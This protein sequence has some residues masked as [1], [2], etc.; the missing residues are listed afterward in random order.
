MNR[1]TSFWVMLVTCVVAQSSTVMHVSAAVI[2]P[3]LPA[4]SQY[5]IV[6]VT[7]DLTTATS[8]VIGDYNNFV[9]SEAAQSA[10]LVALGVQWNAVVSTAGGGIAKVNAPST[11][12]PVYNT[13]GIEVASGATGLYVGSSLPL[14]SPIQ[15]DQFGLASSPV[16]VWTGSTASGNASLTLGSSF[17][18]VGVSTTSTPQSWMTVDAIPSGQVATLYALSTPITVIPEPASLTLLGTAALLLGGFA[19]S[20]ARTRWLG[21]DRSRAADRG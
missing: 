5:Q 2:L 18:A 3:N 6:F 4:G 16:I 8:S 9:T 20:R 19:F 17:V 13:A 11:G 15:Y 7:S 12:L 21:A 1:T 14:L 10:A